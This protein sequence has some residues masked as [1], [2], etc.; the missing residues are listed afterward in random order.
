MTCSF[1]AD[2][3]LA[4]IVETLLFCSS[5]LE[6]FEKRPYQ[7]TIIEVCVERNSIVY[8]PTG[9]GKSYIAIQV[10]KHFSEQLER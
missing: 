8:L 10:I 9:S 4:Y 1:Y 2:F 3:L 7:Q 5:Q 6:D